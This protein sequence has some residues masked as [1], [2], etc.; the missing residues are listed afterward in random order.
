MSS[1]LLSLFLPTCGSKCG[2][3]FPL[4]MALFMSLWL[5][6]AILSLLRVRRDDKVPFTLILFRIN[7]TCVAI[8]L[9]RKTHF[10]ITSLFFCLLPIF[11]FSLL[12][13]ILIK[14]PLCEEYVRMKHQMK[15]MRKK[16]KVWKFKLHFISLE[17]ALLTSRMNVIFSPFKRK[18]KEE[19]IYWRK[20]IIKM[21]RSLFYG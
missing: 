17:A 6:S 19:E 12:Y 7:V 2:K 10:R 16:K 4:R 14:I 13:E 15:I 8:E 21:V 20:N 3:V 1:S 11:F 9:S 18:E 5:F